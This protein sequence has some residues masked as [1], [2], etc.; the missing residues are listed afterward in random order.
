[1]S[2][3]SLRSTF[4][5]QPIASSSIR[6][7]SISSTR[8]LVSCARCG[9]IHGRS[10]KKKTVSGAFMSRARSINYV[11]VREKFLSFRDSDTL[12]EDG[13]CIRL[14]RSGL[15]FADGSLRSLNSPTVLIRKRDASLSNVQIRARSVIN[16]FLVVLYE[17]PR[18]QRL[19][20]QFPIA[21]RM[22]RFL[23]SC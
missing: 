3:G 12:S 2:N 8:P 17:R 10:G 16:Y 11:E 15:K 4:L 13:F 7:F 1:L 5:F 14:A 22:G 23:G 9:V 6:S 21:S 19:L 18:V 20:Q